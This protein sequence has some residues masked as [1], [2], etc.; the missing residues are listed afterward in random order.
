MIIVKVSREEPSKTLRI[1]SEVKKQMAAWRKGWR[2][3]THGNIKLSDDPEEN[4][5][6]AGKLVE[7]SRETSAFLQAAFSTTL[8]NTDHRKWIAHNG[9]SDC[10][11]IHTHSSIYCWQQF[12][13]GTVAP[14]TAI[15]EGSDASKWRLNRCMYS[16][17]IRLLF[18]EECKQSYGAII[19]VGNTNTIWR[20]ISKGYQAD[21][22]FK[23]IYLNT[24]LRISRMAM[25]VVSKAAA[26]DSRHTR[27][28]QRIPDQTPRNLFFTLYDKKYCWSAYI[29]G[30]CESTIPTT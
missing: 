14:L 18:I 21:Y 13:L 20:G 19:P 16:C 6:L 2:Y 9:I 1:L 4:E 7:L 12:W 24:A 10:D 11:K 25:G 27:R 8:S 17:S 3:A 28:P 30:W 23:V 5:D 29:T 15:L 26:G 22:L